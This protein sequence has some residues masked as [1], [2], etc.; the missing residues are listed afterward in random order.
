MRRVVSADKTAA[1]VNGIYHLWMSVLHADRR[2]RE[3]ER[4]READKE[5][6]RQKERERVEKMNDKAITRIKRRKNLK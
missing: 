3:R 1:G 2:E 6:E 5:R 4:E